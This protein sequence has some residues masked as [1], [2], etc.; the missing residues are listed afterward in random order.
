MGY[1][2]LGMQRW[3]STM[4]PRKYLGG[5]SKPDGGGT[6]PSA[7]ADVK[8]FYHIKNRNFSVLKSKIFSA[9]YKQQLE[10]ELET[11]KRNNYFKIGASVVLGLA[12][13]ILI[14]LYFDK[15]LTLF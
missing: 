6:A 14:Y 12:I 8:N 15:H 3:I 11:E 1:C 7:S 10:T 5:R 4:K 2:G 9:K 13:V